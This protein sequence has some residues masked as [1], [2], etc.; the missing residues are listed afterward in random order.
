MILKI[1]NLDLSQYITKN[2]INNSLEVAQSE[3]PQGSILKYSHCKY[4]IQ[5]KFLSETIKEQIE[6]LLESDSI[7]FIID[8]DNFLGY[9]PSYSAVCHTKYY[10]DVT[11]EIADLS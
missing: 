8:T 11:L 4:Q 6:S 10:Y 5:L 9:I 1:S 2:G 7:K 3:Q